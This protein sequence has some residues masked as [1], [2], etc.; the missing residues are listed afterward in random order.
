M[1]VGCTLCVVWLSWCLIHFEAT[2]RWL[3]MSAWSLWSVPLILLFAASLEFRVR[4]VAGLIAP[5]AGVELAL[6][7]IG[8]ACLPAEFF[9][10]LIVPWG[11]PLWFPPQ[12]DSVEDEREGLVALAVALDPHA[13]AGGT[14]PT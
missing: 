5:S 11:L 13:S 6:L 14:G 9:S 7:I 12:R 8:L 10:L 1:N 2:R 4:I 3:I